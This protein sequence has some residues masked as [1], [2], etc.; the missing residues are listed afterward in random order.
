MDRPAMQRLLADVRDG[1][2][3]V[4]VVY[5]VD[6]LTRRLVDFAKIVEVLDEAGASFLS[7]PRRSTQPTRWG[8]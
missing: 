1:K 5:K 6:R 7:V 8:G 4:I 2:V 3:D